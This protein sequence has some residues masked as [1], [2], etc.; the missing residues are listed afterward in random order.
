MRLMTFDASLPVFIAGMWFAWGAYWMVAALRTKPT[1]WRE[2][3]ASRASHVVLLLAAAI[4]L[5]KPR[6]LPL[7]L[8]ARCV[9]AGN[10]IPTLG[11]LIVA[12]GLG[13]AAWARAHL[14]RNWSGIITVKEGHTL[15]RTGP[16]RVVR[17]PIYTGLLLAVI[18]TAAAIGEW[19][20]VLAILCVLAGFLRKIQV[21]EKRMSENFPEYLQYRQH[22]AALIPLLY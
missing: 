17:H 4:L 1:L 9:P 21:E 2:S 12:A 5:A 16:Y 10:L 6:W 19:R 8:S 11:A 13:F 15:V 20:G 22:T 7:I 14:G 3:I 18:G